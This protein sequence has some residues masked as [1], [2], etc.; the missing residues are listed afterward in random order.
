VIVYF[1]HFFENGKSS[2]NFYGLLFQQ[3]D[4]SIDFNR[5]WVGLLFGRSFFSN[6]SGHPDYDVHEPV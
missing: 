2:P 4:L 6:S 1:G 3:R 5:K